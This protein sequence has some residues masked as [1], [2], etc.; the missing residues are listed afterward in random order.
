MAICHE[1]VPRT[2]G[3]MGMRIKIGNR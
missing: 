2:R 3:F 1:D